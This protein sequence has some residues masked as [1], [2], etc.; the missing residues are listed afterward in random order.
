MLV[1][2]WYPTC[3]F[4]HLTN[5]VANVVIINVSVGISQIFH[6]TTFLYACSLFWNFAF[7]KRWK[8]SYSRIFYPKDEILDLISISIYQMLKCLCYTSH[9]F[10]SFSAIT[11]LITVF[12]HW[13]QCMHTTLLPMWLTKKPLVRWKKSVW[14]G[15]AA[16][17]RETTIEGTI[18]LNEG[19]CMI[20]ILSS[21]CM[22]CHEKFKLYLCKSVW[23]NVLLLVNL[24]G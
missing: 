18:L 19:I 1:L 8:W 4:A 17:K 14:E 5:K 7:Y 2:H 20:L 21:T 6:T 11:G 23:V 15:D 24:I 12:L 10:R 3:I 13:L 16:S 9:R 22:K